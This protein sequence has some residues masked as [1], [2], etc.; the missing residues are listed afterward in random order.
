[1]VCEHIECTVQ[2]NGG[3][4]Q[5]WTAGSEEMFWKQEQLTAFHRVACIMEL[6]GL[7]SQ[8]EY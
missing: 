6:A 5:W 8:S 2:S 3:W 4:T 7:A 1:M